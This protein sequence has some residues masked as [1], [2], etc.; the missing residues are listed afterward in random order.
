MMHR[1][2]TFLAKMHNNMLTPHKECERMVVFK[3][4][5]MERER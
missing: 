5:I 2:A 4:I 3:K 1:E